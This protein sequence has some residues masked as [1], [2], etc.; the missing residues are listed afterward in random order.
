MY[1]YFEDIKIA[2]TIGKYLGMIFF[3]LNTAEIIYKPFLFYTI[4][5]LSIFV[6]ASVAFK[7]IHYYNSNGVVKFGD[8]LFQIS[9]LLSF[10]IRHS[11]YYSKR[12]NI[13]QIVLSIGNS[14]LIQ[15]RNCT[16]QKKTKRFEYLFYCIFSLLTAICLVL[17]RL[18]LPDF[19]WAYFLLYAKA[20]HL[21]ALEQFV[22]WK[23]TNTMKKQFVYI[24]ETLEFIAVKTKE[25]KLKLSKRGRCLKLLKFTNDAITEMTIEASNV[26]R[27]LRD[28]LE[29]IRKVFGFVI[30]GC[31]IEDLMFFVLCTHYIFSTLIVALRNGDDADGI[32]L[33]AYLCLLMFCKFVFMTFMW[34]SFTVEVLQ[35]LT[36]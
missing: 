17:Y 27:Y 3:R 9:S 36:N 20:L 25:C 19:H 6:V 15:N 35:I 32:L 21:G 4:F 28:I 2:L 11:T 12:E 26:H 10:I 23:F 24:N 33:V 18:F 14:S 5:Y 29:K 30:F 34:T 16:G 31:L 13:K 7:N 8:I 22:L 1:N